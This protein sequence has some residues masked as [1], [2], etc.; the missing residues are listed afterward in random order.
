MASKSPKTKVNPENCYTVLQASRVLKL[1][2]KRVR[3]MIEEGKLTK[4][5]TSPVLVPQ[6][7]VLALRDQR[8]KN[9]TYQR[10]N[11]PVDQME[12][13]AISFSTIIKQIE[14]NS[15]KALAMVS[16]TNTRNEENFHRQINDLKAELERERAQLE[17]ERAR[18][19]F[20]R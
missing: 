5:G 3:Q 2:V 15:Q 17:K 9:P 13:L 16:E 11:T 1:S 18:R 8:E 4:A 14:E 12:Q 7:E 20:K 10:K 19:W 6:L